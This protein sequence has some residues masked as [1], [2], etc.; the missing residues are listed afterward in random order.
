MYTPLPE[1]LTI[2][3]SEIHGLG[4]FAVSDI[5]AGIVLGISHVV[6]SRFE[7]GHIRTPLGGFY[8][9]SNEPNCCTVKT[10]YLV[11][12]KTIKDIKAGAEITSY[13]FLY[14]PL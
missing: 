11:Y 10:K 13:Y 8:N 3:Q 4:L 2:K 9:H 12:L 5:P 1:T 7:N 14:S 6:D